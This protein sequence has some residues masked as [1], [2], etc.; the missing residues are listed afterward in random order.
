M[1][2]GRVDH[3]LCLKVSTFSCTRTRI[4]QP[5]TLSI[6]ELTLVAF[7]VCTLQQ[8]TTLSSLMGINPWVGS[9]CSLS[10]AI[11]HHSLQWLR[12]LRR[13]FSADSPYQVIQRV[14]FIR[15]IFRVWRSHLRG[16]I[17]FRSHRQ[18]C[19]HSRLVDQF[20]THGYTFFTFDREVYFQ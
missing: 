7:Q 18:T 9:T 20:S 12:L 19:T 5:V 11:P 13:L 17:L 10:R 6:S 8:G 4:L 1:T 2:V 15:S 3:K 16:H 14:A